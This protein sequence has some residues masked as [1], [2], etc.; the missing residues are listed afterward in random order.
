MKNILI[1]IGSL[2]I[3]VACQEPINLKL[4]SSDSKIVIEA[5]YSSLTP[6]IYAIITKNATYF[7]NDSIQGIKDADII[8][9]IGDTIVHLKNTQNGLYTA[10]LSKKYLFKTYTMSV[11]ENG[12]TYEATSTMPQS[13]KIDSVT[14]KQSEGLMARSDGN[15]KDSTKLYTVNVY[16]KD[17]IG[18]NYY[19]IILYKNDER[20]TDNPYSEEQV[21]DDSYFKTN[22]TIN[23][24]LATKCMG[25]ETIRAE[26]MSIDK[27]AYDY[28]ISLLTTMQ[29]AGGSF[30]VP[31]NPL[32][33]F[34]N[35]ALGFF[36]A[37]GS[38]T[39]S[40]KVPMP[41]QTK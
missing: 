39:V 33:N 28:Y 4:K 29:A 15:S 1:I 23:M 2:F 16:F 5:K 36:S 18:R 25:N 32:S 38:D 19:K 37:Y 41:K 40:A 31:E 10:S 13:V 20:L 34:N 12:K 30:S 9:T 27:A 22:T 3:L 21:F 17:P 11:V 8:V 7:G 26:L 24:P 6:K 14:I 35:E